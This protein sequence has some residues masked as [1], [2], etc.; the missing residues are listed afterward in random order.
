MSFGS[1]SDEFLFKL[2]SIVGLAL[3]VV[4]SVWGCPSQDQAVEVLRS[5]GYTEIETHSSPAL[6]CEREIFRTGFTARHASGKRVEGVVCCGALKACTV[7][8]YG[9]VRGEESRR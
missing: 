5:E 6:A 9:R 3:V 1:E 7:R 2:V 8:T 4:L